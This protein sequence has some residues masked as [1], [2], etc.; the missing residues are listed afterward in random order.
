MPTLEVEQKQITKLVSPQNSMRHT[1]A[2][3][4]K[5]RYPSY[6]TIREENHIRI[7][8]KENWKKAIRAPEENNCI[9]RPT[10]VQETQ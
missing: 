5:Q 7:E 1:I 9:I 10:V 3:R 2:Y 6:G 8:R 4:T